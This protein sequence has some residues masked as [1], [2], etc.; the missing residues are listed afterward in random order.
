MKKRL[1]AKKTLAMTMAALMAAGMLAAAPR[2]KETT[3]A[4][5]G[6]TTAAAADTTA[7]GGD[8]AAAE[9]TRRAGYH[10]VP[11]LGG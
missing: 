1:F 2:S 3:A 4:P 11:L 8:A 5:A 6:D 10:Q 7:A 9:G